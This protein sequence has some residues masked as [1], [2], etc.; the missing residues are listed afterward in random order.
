MEVLVE[1]W[2]QAAR[3]DP[4]QM[5]AVTWILEHAHRL[6]AER[7]RLVAPPPTGPD[8][9]RGAT[10]TSRPVPSLTERTVSAAFT[11][12]TG[13]QQRAIGLA[14]LG[15]ATQYDIAA[16]LDETIAGVKTL[17][18]DGLLDLRAAFRARDRA[19]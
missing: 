16:Q 3:F 9:G 11:G 15:S 4:T 10:P 13:P 1:V 19:D 17:L 5:P 8:A 12:L 6:A 7:D 2:R 18:R 14:S